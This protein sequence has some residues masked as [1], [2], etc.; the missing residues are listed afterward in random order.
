[1]RVVKNNFRPKLLLATTNPGKLSEMK[2]L[3]GEQWW[4]LV[5][6]AHLQLHIEVEETGESY[7]ANATRKAQAWAAA[8]GCWVLADDSGLEVLALEGAPG[9]F[10]ARYAGLNRTDAQR[11]EFLLKKLAPYPRP[12]LA[13]FVA[14]VAL[15]HPD[16]FLAVK[17][18][19]CEGE[20][21]PENRGTMGF[22]YDPIFLVADSGKTMAELTMQQKNLR[23]H[24]ARA[25]K[26][27]LPL[28]VEKFG[29]ESQL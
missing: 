27:I 5:E 25:V 4:D 20:I 26:A 12:W 16:G 22:G 2:D 18:G 21:V 7:A 28:L 17:Y 10:S 3:L 19:F 9:L 23:S 13:R 8:S 24:R 11:R 6:P 29:P 1:M 14:C 15:A